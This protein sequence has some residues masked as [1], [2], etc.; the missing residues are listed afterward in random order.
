MLLTE[1]KLHSVTI[2]RGRISRTHSMYEV[3]GARMPHTVGTRSG[4]GQIDYV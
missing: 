4:A 2:N 1:E 3:I